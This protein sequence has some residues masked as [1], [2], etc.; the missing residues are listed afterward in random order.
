MKIFISWSGE[1]SRIIANELSL[2]LRDVIQVLRPFMSQHDIE[3]G[4]NWSEELDK[5]LRDDS[6]ALIILTPDNLNSPW[7]NYEAGAVHKGINSNKVATIL[8]DIDYSD[9]PSTLSRFNGTLFQKEEIFSLLKS[10]NKELIEGALE[11]SAL[12]RSFNSHWNKLESAYN[13]SRNFNKYERNEL[14]IIESNITNTISDRFTPSTNFTDNISDLVVLLIKSFNKKE[15]YINNIE[16]WLKKEDKECEEANYNLL[17]E[18]LYWLNAL[19]LPYRKEVFK[20]FTE[21]SRTKIDEIEDM[22]NQGRA[23]HH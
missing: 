16:K 15:E 7:I 20:I 18:V 11:E 8:I 5:R 1:K 22:T 21:Y 6:M 23:A 4:L 2:W 19:E 13:K 9:L 10:I 17:K 12:A 3:K 14:A